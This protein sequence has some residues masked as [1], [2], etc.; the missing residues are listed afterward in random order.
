[1][2]LVKLKKNGVGVWKGGLYYPKA[3]KKEAMI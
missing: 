2:K 1:M 3:R